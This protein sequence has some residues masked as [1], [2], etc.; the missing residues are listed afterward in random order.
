MV[1]TLVLAAW[2]SVQ[3]APLANIYLEGRLQG[4]TSWGTILFVAPGNVIEYRLV[5]DMAQVGTQNARGTI[6]SLVNSGLQSLSLAIVQA[7]T[8][9]AQ[10]DFNPPTATQTFR[11]GWGTG[12]GARVGTLSPRLPG[13]LNDLRDIRPIRAPGMFSAVD[14]EVIMQGGTFTVGPG[15]GPL[16]FGRLTPTWDTG[17]GAMRING[18]G[19]ILFTANDQAGADPLVGFQPL[20]LNVP[21][22]ATIGLLGMGLAGFFAATR[23]WRGGRKLR[24]DW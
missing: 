2:T 11:N 16:F 10:V 13:G 15:G 22:P 17:P 23:R 14:P 20:V 5:A 4:T 1:G 19:Q 21:E 3:A 8:D 12:T 24:R 6:S 9:G 7:P 18:A